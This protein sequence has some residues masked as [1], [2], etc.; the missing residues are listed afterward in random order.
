MSTRTLVSPRN[1]RFVGSMVKESTYL[2]G[3][4][5]AGKRPSSRGAGGAGMATGGFAAAVADEMPDAVE[6]ATAADSPPQA[7]RARAMTGTRAKRA[8]AR[9][10]WRRPVAS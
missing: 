5:V 2:R 4:A 6:G 8:M 3:V 1:L 10:S 7:D 9:H